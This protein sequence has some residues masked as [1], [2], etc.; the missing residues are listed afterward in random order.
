MT[1]YQKTKLR[2]YWHKWGI[3]YSFIAFFIIVVSAIGYE[4]RSEQKELEEY[5]EPTQVSREIA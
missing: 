1:K 3:A 2:V 4:A 5:Y